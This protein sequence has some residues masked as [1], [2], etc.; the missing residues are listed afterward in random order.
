[1]VKRA[2]FLWLF[3]LRGFCVS[4][5]WCDDRSLGM[6]S[7]GVYL[8]VCFRCL[9]IEQLGMGVCA[10]ER[11]MIFVV[12]RYISSMYAEDLAPRERRR[13]PRLPRLG[14][15]GVVSTTHVNGSEA[16][17]KSNIQTVPTC[18]YTP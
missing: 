14:L 4:G 3:C 13:R 7:G 16:L 15:V 2:M 1:V 8:R 18:A 6:T 17:Y 9:A 12:C 11:W 5:L 10:C